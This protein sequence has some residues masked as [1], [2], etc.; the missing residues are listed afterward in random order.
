MPNP[1]ITDYID[2]LENPRG[3]F[4]TLG[5]V[6]VERDHYGA[7]L[8][9]AGN[10]AAVFTYPDGGRRRMLKCYIRPNPHLRAVYGY[11]ERMRPPLLPRA[12]LLAGE[13]FV[14]T[15]G[16]AGEWVDVVEGEW[17]E[18][19][20]LAEAAGRAV[21]ARDTGRLER[22][23]EEFE[24]LRAALAAA[25][26]AHGDLKPDNIVVRPDGAMTL[27][28][29][30]ALWIP[31][32]AGLPS[33]EL[34]TPPYRHPARTAADFDKTIDRRPGRIIAHCL[35]LLARDPAARAAYATFDE[36]AERVIRG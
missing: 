2:A 31:E 15:S 32:L 30:D 21:R 1:T 27:V 8:F 12:R 9:R 6:A 25:E 20:T 7:P 34:G 19:V 13:L 17:V 29:C 22:L 11:I 16:D 33:A 18:G 26:W 14:Y 36:M 24:R 3:V 4:R 28:D 35:G 10:S 5:E 23:A